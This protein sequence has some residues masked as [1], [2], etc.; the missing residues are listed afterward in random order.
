[1]TLKTAYLLD[2]AKFDALLGTKK[3]DVSHRE[4]T[5]SNIDAMPTTPENVPS[6]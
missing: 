1:M 5:A 3:E 6:I 4:A 2:T